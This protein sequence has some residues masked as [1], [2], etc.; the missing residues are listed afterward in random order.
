[1]NLEEAINQR[2]SIRKYQDTKVPADFVEKL[3]A[4]VRLAPSA[5]NAQPTKLL[6]IADEKTKQE[7]RAN[8]IFRQEFVYQAP[9]IIAFLADPA[10]YPQEKFEPVFSNA[11]EIGGEV[12][13][14]RDLSIS[15]Q[16][17]VLTATSLGLGTCYIGIVNRNK[18]KEMF[19]LPPNYVLP[20][21]IIAGF[22]GEESKPLIRKDASEFINWRN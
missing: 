12:G 5:Y 11:A 15:A 6:I 13:A 8:N 14:V 2:R 21:V 7:L 22:P 17:L 16:N 19:N 1:M 9:L 20:F 10:V 3:I 18:F 4:A